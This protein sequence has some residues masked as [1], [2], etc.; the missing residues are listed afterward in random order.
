MEPCEKADDIEAVEIFRLSSRGGIEIHYHDLPI[1][2]IKT[3][4]IHGYHV[5]V[6]FDPSGVRRLGEYLLRYADRLDKKHPSFGAKPFTGE[7]S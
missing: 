6:P 4:G 5:G 1:V 7:T 3:N 2:T